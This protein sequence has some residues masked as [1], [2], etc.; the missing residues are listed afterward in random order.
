MYN[1]SITYIVFI[2]TIHKLWKILNR[3]KS[4]HRTISTT[5]RQLIRKASSSSSNGKRMNS[6]V[7]SFLFPII[8]MNLMNLRIYKLFTPITLLIHTSR[9]EAFSSGRF[10]GSSVVR[11]KKISEPGIERN[12]AETSDAKKPMLLLCRGISHD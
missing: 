3:Y 6:Y 7:A 11:Q 8:C 5:Q 4:I 1:T 10:L 9:I 12:D 2:Q